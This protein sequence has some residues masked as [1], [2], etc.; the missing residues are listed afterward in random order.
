MPVVRVI[1]GVA[2]RRGLGID[3]ALL[4]AGV[5]VAKDV[6]PLRVRGHDAVLDAVVNHLDEVACAARAAMQ[7]AVLSGAAELL[8]AWRPGR[9]IDVGRQG[10]ENGV[11]APDDR[12]ITADH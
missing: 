1:L 5:G 2:Q 10:G 6:Q 12:F 9:R 4:L 3:G 11:D 7:V 8:P